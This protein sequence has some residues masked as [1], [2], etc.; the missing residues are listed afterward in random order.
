[1]IANMEARLIMDRRIVLIPTAFAELVVREAPAPVPGSRHRFKYRLTLV[2]DGVCL[3]RFDNEAGEGDHARAGE[4]ERPY[5][6]TNIDGLIV[7]FRAHV[8]RW[9]H[10]HGNS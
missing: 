3:V 2:A 5:R 6:F 1:M 4:T 8:E 10:E 9:L 7:D